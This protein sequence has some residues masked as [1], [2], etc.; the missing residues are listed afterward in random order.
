[1]LKIIVFYN[2]VSV[3]SEPLG[4]ENGDIPDENIRASH[5]RNDKRA[6]KGRLNGKSFW[7]TYKGTYPSNQSWIQ[8]DICYQTLISGVATQGDGQHK[9][10]VTSLKVSS[11]SMNTSDEE[12]FIKDTKGNAMVS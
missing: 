4:M 11:F 10:W 8:A 12:V 9:E 1:M 6:K 3:C 7:S 5:E 2:H